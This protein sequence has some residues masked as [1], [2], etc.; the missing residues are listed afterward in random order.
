MLRSFC[1]CTLC[2]SNSSKPC[3]FDK[4]CDKERRNGSE[5]KRKEEFRISTG[6]VAYATLFL[7]C[8][9]EKGATMLLPCLRLFYF[10]KQAGGYRIDHADRILV[11][12][13]ID[14]VK[15][16]SMRDRCAQTHA[17]IFFFV[18]I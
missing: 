13:R 14:L 6:S 4:L 12:E 18:G 7:F 8:I 16:K 17:E 10:G 9:P 1:F 3:G 5:E 2:G 15:H 11:A